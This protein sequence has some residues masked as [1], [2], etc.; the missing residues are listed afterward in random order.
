MKKNYDSVASQLPLS[1]TISFTKEKTSY[2]TKKRIYLSLFSVFVALFSFGLTQAQTTLLSP[3]GDGG[4]ENGTTLAAN[5]WTAVNSS[6]DNWIAGTTPLVSAGTRCA[7]ISSTPSGTQTW[8]Y[9]QVSSIQH[10]YYDLN[11]KLVVKELQHLIG[12][13]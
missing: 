4:F 2:S 1:S 6:T 7:F 11:G 13:T 10:M 5:N 3:T 9:S 8:T 12:T